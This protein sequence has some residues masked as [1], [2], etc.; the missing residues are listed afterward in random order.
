MMLLAHYGYNIGAMNETE[1]YGQVAAENLERVRSLETSV[2][3]IGWTLKAMMGYIVYIPYL[4]IVY[5]VSKAI[6]P[7]KL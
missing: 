4:L 6:R 2:M 3:G 7:R 5:F 1:R